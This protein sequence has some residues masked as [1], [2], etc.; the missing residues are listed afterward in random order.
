M[1]FYDC[2]KEIEFPKPSAFPNLSSHIVLTLS[3]APIYQQEDLEAHTKWRYTNR[4]GSMECFGIEHM[5]I[6]RW[7]ELFD[8]TNCVF[9]IVF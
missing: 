9:H 2:Y 7:S 4:L 6:R 3:P 5:R 8:F 1:F